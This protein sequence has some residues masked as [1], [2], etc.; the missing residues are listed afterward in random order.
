MAQILGEA[1][2]T[3]LVQRITSLLARE[4]PC[5]DLEPDD[6]AACVPGLP[7][8]LLKIDG[9]S[10]ESMRLPWM[11]LADVGWKAVIAAVSDIVAKAGRPLAVVVSIGLPATMRLEETVDLIN[12]AMKAAREVGAWL[13]GGDSNRDPRGQGWVDV[14]VVGVAEKPVPRRPRPGDLVYTTIGRYGLTGVAF[15][16]LRENKLGILGNYPRVLEETKRPRPR[17]GFTELAKKLGNCLTASMDVSDGLGFTL[18]SLAVKAGTSIYVERIPI[19]KEAVEY[20]SQEGIDPMHLAL[21]AGEEYEIVFTV[22]K[23]CKQ[24]VEEVA[25]STNTPVARIGVLGEG[26]GKPHVFLDNKVVRAW[27]WDSF[28][29][30]MAVANGS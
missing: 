14:A 29:G 24:V 23:D 5:K 17:L 7:G 9:Y 12:G 2:E 20:A 25:A 3:I 8:V 28:K 15:H 19:E 10:I 21:Y 22:K 26:K 30:F 18:Y 1:G 27:R 4:W 16:A 11:S 13:V 6:D